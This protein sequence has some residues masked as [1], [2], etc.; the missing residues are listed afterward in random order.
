M[1]AVAKI[2]SPK[3]KPPTP[4]PVLQRQLAEARAAEEKRKA[5]AE[6]KKEED[7]IQQ[8]RNKRG[9]RSLFAQNN[10]G[11]GFEEIEEKKTVLG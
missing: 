5:D 2:F 3:P 6:A 7:R 1:G 4:D 11:N 8:A 10:S 9:R